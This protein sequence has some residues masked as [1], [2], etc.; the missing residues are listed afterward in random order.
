MR[1]ALLLVCFLTAWARPA[2][3]QTDTDWLRNP[4]PLKVVLHVQKHPVLT[5]DFVSQLRLELYAGL[6]QHFGGVVAVRTVDAAE[7]DLMKDVLAKGWSVLDDKN[8]VREEKEH[9]L[10]LR[11]NDGAYELESRQRDGFTG[12]C[13]ALRT[14]R[15]AD[16]SWVARQASLL[17]VEDFG[18]V[19]EVFG[20][21]A[22]LKDTGVKL[23]LK[24]WT[25]QDRAL[26]LRMQR[27]EVFAFTRIKQ[28]A[29]G[30]LRSE[31]VPDALLEVTSYR[32]QDD[33]CSAIW[34]ARFTKVSPFAPDSGRTKSFRALRLGTRQA[35][36]KLRLTDKDSGNPVAGCKVIV[37][38][39]DGE[40]ARNV[41]LDQDANAPGT[42]ESKEPFAHFAKVVI[43]QGNVTLAEVP[44]PILSEDIIPL[45]LQGVTE[46]RKLAEFDYDYTSWRRPL[47][48]LIDFIDRKRKERAEL[49]ARGDKAGF[50]RV[51]KE[52][53]DHVGRELKQLKDGFEDIKRLAEQ[54]GQAT[55]QRIKE[56][57]RYM[58][59]LDEINK[60]FATDIQ[61]IENPKPAE[62][63]EDLAEVAAGNY[64]Y[65]AA[66]KHY[67]QS[68]KLNPEQPELKKKLDLMARAWEQPR[69]TALQEARKFINDD[70][71][72]SDWQQLEEKL[73]DLQKH[74][75]EVKRSRDHLTAIR[76]VNINQKH[77]KKLIEVQNNLGNSE[78]DV[79][80]GQMIT[81]VGKD[82]I[83]MNDELLT[84]YKDATQP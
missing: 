71:G 29:D 56:G 2:L 46:A 42:F 12:L 53:S 60:R 48:E 30:K 35:T 19:A 32:D 9:L 16:R 44:V 18:V 70:W 50:L 37:R 74:V 84:F 45:E 3:A 76:L 55:Q 26:A 14:A 23:R 47:F 64:D 68:L 10:I 17:V 72:K 13:S 75:A 49:R 80:K 59:Q 57:N 4:Y 51:T 7:S 66:L 63:E 36:V 77:Q 79:L 83:T 41:P 1:T 67:R 11:F 69:N 61:R 39:G 21:S 73:A 40:H 38:R 22:N 65:D 20:T 52:M 6:K 33:F 82:L 24:A 5:E 27:G 15:T 58:E 81:K 25:L 31:R 34:H 28:D 78:A 43:T 8:E 62:E 54:A